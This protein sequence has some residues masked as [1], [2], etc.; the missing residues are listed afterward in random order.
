VGSTLAGIKGSNGLDN[1]RDSPLVVVEVGGDR[2]GCKER[3]R[4]AGAFASRPGS[5][6]VLPGNL[7]PSCHYPQDSVSVRHPEF[8]K[9]VQR[10]IRG[11]KSIEMVRLKV[12]D[13]GRR[14]L[15]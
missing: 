3:P 12:T 5:R 6:G 9:K 14:A 15:G 11:D 8:V 13:A 2:L 4:A 7:C 1:A 10:A